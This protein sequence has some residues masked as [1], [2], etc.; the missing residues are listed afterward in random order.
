MSARQAIGIWYAGIVYVAC[1]V[2]WEVFSVE[3]IDLQ[4]KKI[5]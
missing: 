3:I 5:G 2:L 1:T 4:N